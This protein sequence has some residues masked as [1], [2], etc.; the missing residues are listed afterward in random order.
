MPCHAAPPRRAATHRSATSSIRISKEQGE[1]PKGGI[2]SRD[3]CARC[4]FHQAGSPQPP[5]LGA[6]AWRETGL[7]A[8]PAQLS[9]SRAAESCQRKARGRAPWAA[10]ATSAFR[11]TW[12]ARGPEK[13]W[14]AIDAAS[15]H[16]HKAKFNPQGV[17]R[18]S[19]SPRIPRLNA[20]AMGDISNFAVS[21]MG[22]SPCFG[23]SSTSPPQTW[24]GEGL[25]YR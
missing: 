6:Q 15:A 8:A 22:L 14:L 7:S 16:P 13:R 1:H 11:K 24:Q 12:R 23:N 25:F 9:A 3:G 10:E 19:M 18:S 17:A 4:I 21:F 20:A 5:A 2:D